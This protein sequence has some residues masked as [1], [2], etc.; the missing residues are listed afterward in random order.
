ME[1]NIISTKLTHF[2]HHFIVISAQ[3]GAAHVPNCLPIPEHDLTL[4]P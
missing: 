1:L 2:C 3:Q 4:I